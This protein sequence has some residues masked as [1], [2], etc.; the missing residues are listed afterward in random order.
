MDARD[1][2]LS[3]D[4]SALFERA[5]KARKRTHA[6]LDAIQQ[7]APT[8]AC[9]GSQMFLCRAIDVVEAI[10]CF[11][12]GAMTEA[13]LEAWAERTEMAEEIEYA[14]DHREAVAEALFQLAHPELNGAI[15]T[16]RALSIRRG[17]LK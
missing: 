7:A 14:E 10:N 8:P 5:D 9:L 13:G 12:A 15:T 3:E 1:D 2:L 17:L 11:L 6:M 4:P 16:Q